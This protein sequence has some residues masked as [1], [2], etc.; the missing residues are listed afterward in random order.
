VLAIFDLR[1][2]AQPSFADAVRL[3]GWILSIIVDNAHAYL[4]SGYYGASIP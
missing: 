4:P 1:D 2:P 3:N